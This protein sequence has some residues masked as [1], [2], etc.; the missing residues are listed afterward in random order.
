MDL[1]KENTV[2]F[3]DALLVDNYKQAHKF[4]EVIVQEKVK[5]KIKK[6]IDEVHPFKKAKSKKSKDK[7]KVVKE[8][9]DG[10]R[11]IDLTELLPDGS[12]A[13]AALFDFE[14]YHGGQNS[15]MYGVRSSGKI[16]VNDI[17]A[18]KSE[19]LKATKIASQSDEI[20]HQEN[21]KALYKELTKLE[22][23][24]EN[25]MGSGES[26]VDDSEYIE[27]M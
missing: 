24:F 14:H 12:S 4:L 18:L 23:R 15:H 5:Q 11:I 25:V 1:I 19:V 9:L 20:E 8:D 2:K 7:K 21:F 27:P 10:S 22:K 3:I 6:G 16:D 26:F 17:P 13:L